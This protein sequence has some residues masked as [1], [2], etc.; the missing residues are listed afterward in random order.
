MAYLEGLLGESRFALKKN[1]HRPSMQA[2]LE[3]NS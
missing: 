2:N 1:K 3:V